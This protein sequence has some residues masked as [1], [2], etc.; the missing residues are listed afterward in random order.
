[1]KQIIEPVY[2]QFGAKVQS[3]RETLGWKQEEM[4]KKLDMTRA[5][6]AN[7]EG[8]NQRVLLHTVDEFAKAFNVEPKVLM[9]G[10]WT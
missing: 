10:I 5:S 9:R 3:I 1:M 7:I 6:L 8:G 2:R 4:A